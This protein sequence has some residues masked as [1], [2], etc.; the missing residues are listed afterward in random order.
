M[1]WKQWRNCCTMRRNECLRRL[2]LRCVIFVLALALPAGCSIRPLGAPASSKP[3]NTP[4]AQNAMVSTTPTPETV[5][6]AGTSVSTG[7]APAATR[8]ATRT[9]EENVPTDTPAP[10]D[11]SPPTNTPTPTEVQDTKTPVPASPTS[12]PQSSP[13]PVPATSTPETPRTTGA[14]RVIDIVDGDTIKVT[15]D[16]REY[17]IRYIGMDTPERGD[18]FYEE[19]TRANTDLVAGQDLWLEKDVSETDRYGRLLRYVYVGDLMVNAELVRRGYARV[20]TFPPDVAHAEMFRQLEQQAREEGAGL[21][22]S[23][24]PAEPTSVP[25]DAPSGRTG[26]S[27]VVAPWCSQFDAPGNDNE[28][29]EE[30]YVC[31]ENQGDQAVEMAGW[32][33]QDEHG[34]TYTFPSFTLAPGAAVR[35]RTGCGEDTSTDLYWCKDGTAVWNNGGDTVF[36]YDGAGNLVTQSSY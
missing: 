30:E 26:S 33:V 18:P 23:G 28:N 5:G 22:A 17:T 2:L 3:T 31:F 21:W 10:T 6:A 13:T 24:P 15:I 11:T 1:P 36:L 16:G 8:T 32:T 9:A 12:T 35:V 29:E 34:W 14:A 4:W 25:S 27:V 20:A 7:S 19:A